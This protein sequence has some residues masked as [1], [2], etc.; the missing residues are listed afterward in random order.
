MGKGTGKGLGKGREGEV[1]ALAA[2]CVL[3]WLVIA[4]SLLGTSFDVI[5]PSEVGIRVSPYTI[6][7]FM[8]GESLGCAADAVATMSCGY[9]SHEFES[10]H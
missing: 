1:G 3:V 2:V 4:C 10:H 9:G 6:H 7:T 8:F 5:K